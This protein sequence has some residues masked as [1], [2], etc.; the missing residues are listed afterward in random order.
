MS[1]K[2]FF[3]T[4]LTESEVKRDFTKL[5]ESR[6]W[7]KFKEDTVDILEYKDAEGKLKKFKVCKM[8]ED[9][10]GP[11]YVLEARG[12]ARYGLFRATEG[13][14]HVIRMKTGKKHLIKPK[15]IFKEVEGKLVFELNMPKGMQQVG[16]GKDVIQQALQN[17][18]KK[19][20]PEQTL[21]PQ[22][23]SHRI[24]VNP[25]PQPTKP[26][27]PNA[28]L[29]ELQVLDAPSSWKDA[30]AQDPEKWTPKPGTVADFSKS[31][32]DPSAIGKALS[33]K[34]HPYKFFVGNDGAVYQVLNDPITR[35]VWAVSKTD[36]DP[37]PYLKQRDPT[38]DA[39][40]NEAQIEEGLPI[41]D[42]ND[43][44][45]M[46][47][48][49]D[50]KFKP[51]SREVADFSQSDADPQKI[52]AILLKKYGEH[53]FRYFIANDNIVYEL[54]PF[55]KRIMRT[56]VDPTPYLKDRSPDAVSK[57]MERRAN[58]EPDKSFP[59]GEP[60]FDKNTDEWN[61]GVYT[62]AKA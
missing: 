21:I 37:A 51:H 31:S 60:T 39:K 41:E 30:I 23:G 53:T 20:N 16:G 14:F 22:G 9:G 48:R 43:E 58:V 24:R 55:S 59:N 19:F 13:N 34:K 26:F 33:G 15:G 1:F 27:D 56:G 46:A 35:G 29:E 4:H 7:G 52:A 8:D 2:H 25:E 28:T 47:Q 45:K 54:D 11:A 5:N 12:G 17:K 50:T 18:K 62:D 42:Y 38:Q 3:R 57:V 40:L 36:L 10:S 49:H 6:W 44:T 32:K 61:K